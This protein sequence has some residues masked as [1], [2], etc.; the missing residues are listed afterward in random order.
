M[1]ASDIEF[2]MLRREKYLEEADH[3][4]SEKNGTG[5]FVNF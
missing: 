4:V 5:P 1:P 2:L 3:L